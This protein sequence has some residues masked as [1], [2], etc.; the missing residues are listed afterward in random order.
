MV[1]NKFLL[2]ISWCIICSNLV[3]S[4]TK[5]FIICPSWSSAG[6]TSSFQTKLGV[7]DYKM[8]I[9]ACVGQAGFWNTSGL[10]QLQ[11]S[12]KPG[13]PKHCYCELDL[14]NKVKG[15]TKR[16]QKLLIMFDILIFQ[17][18]Q[19][20]IGSKQKVFTNF[21]AN[22]QSTLHLLLSEAH[23]TFILTVSAHPPA[24]QVY[25]GHPD[26]VPAQSAGDGVLRSLGVTG[27]TYMDRGKFTPYTPKYSATPGND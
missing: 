26:C 24:V 12:R 20:S 4:W 19:F 18:V 16:K 7:F 11:I 6:V 3:I 10:H 17:N 22:P 14:F 27:A 15:K 21:L 23:I 13:A 9:L 25:F 2:F 5:L 8:V 1:I